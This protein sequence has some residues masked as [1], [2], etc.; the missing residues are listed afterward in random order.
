[1][2][3]LKAVVLNLLSLAAAFGIVVLVFGR[4]TGLRCGTSPRPAP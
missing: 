3:A 1:V 2:L 4:V